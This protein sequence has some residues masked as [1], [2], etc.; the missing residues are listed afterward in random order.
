M[1]MSFLFLVY[2]TVFVFIFY[3]LVSFVC[4]L[5]FLRTRPRL[6]DTVLGTLTTK[7]IFF[8]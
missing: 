2:N 3:F 6:D 4:L 7:Y 1:G 8:F 5:P